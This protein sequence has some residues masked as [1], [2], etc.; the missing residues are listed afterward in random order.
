[1]ESS[2]LEPDLEVIATLRDPTRRRLYEYI[3]RQPRAVSRDEAAEAAHV[4]RALAAFH[5]EK[6]VKVGLLK[7]E[8]RRLSG[9]TGPG[10]GRT[11]KLYRRS[12]HQ[13]AVSVPRRDHELLARLIADSLSSAPR[14]ATGIEPA[15]EYGRALG[16]RAR[17]RV[18]GR[19]APERLLGCVEDVLQSLGF[20][21]YRT[22][23][24]EIRVRN[25]PFDPLSRL[26]TPLVCGIGQALMSGVIEGVAP[27]GTRVDREEHADRCCG[28]ITSGATPGP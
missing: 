5:L 11:S 17:G 12:R 2:P 22:S 24:T 9:R 15:R 18:R 8:Y 6:L 3:E 19:P 21:P 27:E 23:P 25:C 14:S 10:A 4:S 26:F 13:F 16:K 1:M 7:A 28:V 20:D